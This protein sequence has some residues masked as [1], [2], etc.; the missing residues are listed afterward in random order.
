MVEEHIFKVQ[1][2]WLLVP[3]LG[4]VVLMLSGVPLAALSGVS[5]TLTGNSIFTAGEGTDS[6][7]GQ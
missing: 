6:G 2:R 5:G 7:F 1:S 3:L 4:F